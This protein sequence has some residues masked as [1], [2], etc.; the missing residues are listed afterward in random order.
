M[1]GAALEAASNDSAQHSEQDDEG[2]LAHDDKDKEGQ[3]RMN[4]F[5]RSGGKHR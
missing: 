4:V 2:D 3:D 1:I 5:E